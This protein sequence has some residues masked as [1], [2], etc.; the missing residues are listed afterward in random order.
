MYERMDDICMYSSWTRGAAGSREPSVL[1]PFVDLRR[2][3]LTRALLMP[4][5]GCLYLYGYFVFFMLKQKTAP[6]AGCLV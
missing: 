2:R 3:R 1:F 6:A 4:A 5:M